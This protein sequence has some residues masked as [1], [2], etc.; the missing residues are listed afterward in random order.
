MATDLQI[1]VEDR[2]GAAADLGDA[3]AKA[4]INI[5]GACGVVV[6]GSGVMHV[7]VDDPDTA[8]AAL[9]AAGV[10]VGGASEAVVVG[11][12]HDQPGELARVTRAAADAGISLTYM[13]VATDTR[14]VLGADDVVALKAAVGT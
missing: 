14:L 7:L 11:P 9:D 6:G 8:R 13:Y 1:D 4:G 5:L 10:T 3:L 12:L 2:T